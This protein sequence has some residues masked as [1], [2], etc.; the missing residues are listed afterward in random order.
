MSYT[1]IIPRW[2]GLSHVKNSSIEMSSLHHVEI[3]RFGYQ[4]SINRIYTSHKF[5]FELGSISYNNHT[6]EHVQNVNIQ[7]ANDV[8]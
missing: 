1:A 5:I 3:M 6:S 7:Y 8:L 2:I 4:Y